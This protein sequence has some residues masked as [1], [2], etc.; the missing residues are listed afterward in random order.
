MVSSDGQVPSPTKTRLED[1]PGLRQPSGYEGL[2][3]ACS[4]AR[5][6]G[7]PRL[8]QA[9]GAASQRLFPLA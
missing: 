8:G 1:V 9:A 2:W 7:P 5:R 3:P 4:T 6:L